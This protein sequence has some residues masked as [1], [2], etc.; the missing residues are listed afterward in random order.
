MRT[1]KHTKSVWW[2]MQNKAQTKK[3]G[4]KSFTL[5]SELSKWHK[6]CYV[7]VQAGMT[8]QTPSLS[9]LREGTGLPETWEELPS[10]IEMTWTESRLSAAL[11]TDSAWQRRCF[12]RWSLRINLLRQISHSKRF[13]P[14]ATN[15][16]SI[17]QL[18]LNEHCK[19]HQLQTFNKRY[20][21]TYKEKQKTAG[22]RHVF[23]LIY[24]VDMMRSSSCPSI[25]YF[26]QLW[27]LL[28]VSNLANVPNRFFVSG[29]T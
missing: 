2:V 15:S 22:P 4:T 19:H 7:Q 27:L 10:L 23:P 3:T 26:L 21:K 24:G 12:F 16:N 5:H 13:S 28:A 9:P 20:W 18:V 11:A 14:A 8:S 6:D 1:V 17:D 25:L 29:A